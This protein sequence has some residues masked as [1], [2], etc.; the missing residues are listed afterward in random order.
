MKT[1]LKKNPT[2][3]EEDTITSISGGRPEGSQPVGRQ[4]VCPYCR[5][6]YIPGDG[7]NCQYSRCIYCGKPVPREF[8]FDCKAR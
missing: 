2:V 4:Q 1:E 7:H 3:V 8:I 6:L 5:Q